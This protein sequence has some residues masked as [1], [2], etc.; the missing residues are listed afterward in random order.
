MED[1]DQEQEENDPYLQY[2]SRPES[3]KPFHNKEWFRM[4]GD[5][6]KPAPK[7]DRLIFMLNAA[8]YTASN[9]AMFPWLLNESLRQ[10]TNG[11]NQDGDHHERIPIQV[12]GLKKALLSEL[13]YPTR[14]KLEICEV[15]ERVAY[16]A[17]TAYIPSKKMELPPE[18]VWKHYV[19]LPNFK[20]ALYG[21]QIQAFSSVYF[22]YDLFIGKCVRRAGG[23]HLKVHNFEAMQR[24]YLA[25]FGQKFVD[26][27]V[28]DITVNEARLVRHAIVHNG[29]L[30]TD[31]RR[32]FREVNKSRPVEL[33]VLH[34]D[35]LH[36]Y[37]MHVKA[38]YLC[39]TDRVTELCRYLVTLKQ[40]GA[41]RNG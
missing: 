23:Q 35:V 41:K 28:T 14:Q 7:L 33:Y 36:F 5:L 39:L 24:S 9:A 12:R 3:Y 27:F 4:I 32:T 15:L 26:R 6:V 40:F 29:G 19:K 30:D 21:T 17:E 13:N 20:A 38:L 37:P 31:E 25:T 2:D 22:P 34:D 11:Y 18:F 1:Q 16:R 10:V 8:W